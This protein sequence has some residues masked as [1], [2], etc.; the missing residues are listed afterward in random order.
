MVWWQGGGWVNTFKLSYEASLLLLLSDID[1]KEMHGV[2][3]GGNEEKKRGE[4]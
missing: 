3:E 1:R 4:S 2:Q